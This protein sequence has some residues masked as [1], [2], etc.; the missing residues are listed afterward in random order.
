ML[1]KRASLVQFKPFASR[2]G[3]LVELTKASL[4]I[5]STRASGRMSCVERVVTWV[6]GFKCSGGGKIMLRPV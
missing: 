1:R 4:A 2:P 5:R 3:R 6:G